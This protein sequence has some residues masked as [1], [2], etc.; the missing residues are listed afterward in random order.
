VGGFVASGAGGLSAPSGLIFGPDG[1]LYVASQGSDSILSDNGLTGGFVGM[2]VAGRAGG[3]SS[4]ADLAS[5]F[6]SLPYVEK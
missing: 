6:R 4:P 1:N 2:F 3:L 5:L